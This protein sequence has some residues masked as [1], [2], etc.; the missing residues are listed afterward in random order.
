MIKKSYCFI[1]LIALIC[2]ISCDDGDPPNEII[3]NVPYHS[4]LNYNYCAPT[5]IQMWAHYDTGTCYSQNDIASYIGLGATGGIDPWSVRNGVEYYTYSP[6]YVADFCY[7]SPGAQGDLISSCITGIQEYVPAIMP[8]YEA[9]HAVLVIGFE[10]HNE[11]DRP[12]AEVMYYHDPDEYWGAN[13]AVVA[14]ELEEYY[15]TPIYGIYYVII[16]YR[17][18]LYDGID[19]HD[20]FVLRR[21]IYYGGPSIYDPKGLLDDLNI[22]PEI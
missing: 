20:N 3:L 21:G 7:G 2:I 17:S 4:Q 16:G 14:S 6:G 18:F 8:F 5:C 10:W 1:I 11:G 22:D 12:I 9:R 19:G 15:F 13:M